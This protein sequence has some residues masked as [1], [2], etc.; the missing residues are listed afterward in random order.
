MNE[1]NNKTRLKFPGMS[2]RRFQGFHERLHQAASQTKK[3]KEAA[4]RLLPKLGQ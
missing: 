2:E 4:E 3:T 1:S